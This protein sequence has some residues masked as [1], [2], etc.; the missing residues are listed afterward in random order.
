M[1]GSAGA[2]GAP[3]EGRPLGLLVA[4][5]FVA[6]V[7]VFGAVYT[8]GVVLD[9]VGRSLSVGRAA[10]AL[11]PAVAAASLFFLGPFTGRAADRW[12]AARL[13]AAGALLL[14]GGLVL[15]SLA[16]DLALA[17]IG[18]GLVA[19]GAAGC[20]YVPT[21]AAVAARAGPGRPLAAGLVVAGVGTGTALVAPVL[22]A[23]VDAFGWRSAYRLYAA[24]A[25]GVLGCVSAVFA[26]RSA[27]AGSQ[28]PESTVAAGTVP[29]GTVPA[30]T[31]LMG[32]APRSAAPPLLGV[33]RA[34]G[35]ARLYGALL[36][37]SP[38]MYVGLVFLASNARGHGIE[39]GRQAALLTVFGLSGTAARVV[40]AAVGRRVGLGT[41]FRATFVLL[42]ASLLVWASAGGRYPVLVAYAVVAGVGY[43]GLIGLA[44][45]VVAAR[46]GAAGLATT[47]GVLYTSL[48]LGGLISGPAVGAAVDATGYPATLVGLA[49][50]TAVAAALVP[51]AG[52][53][54]S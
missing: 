29:A 38:S 18:F 46:F 8:F 2:A 5:A 21:V 23:A 33:L 48:G 1:V 7:V 16:G 41:V 47:L 9:D 39:G 43:G 15:T 34:E 31:V 51:A 54:Q 32:T 37:A 22:R 53:R 27:P 25:L 30:G 40:I 11:V 24:V 36:L 10:V 14:P 52:A 49:G 50:C 3:A 19:G 4:A 17:V 45:T 20:V 12:G 26:E 44:P 28:V 42:V 6:Q 35:F 13:V